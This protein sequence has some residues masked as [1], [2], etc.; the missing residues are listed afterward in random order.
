MIAS[1]GA[2]TVLLLFVPKLREQPALYGASFLY[3][4]GTAFF[5]V[6]LFQGLERLKVAALA[7]GV[8][9]LLTV[10]AL[11]LFVHSERD[12]AVAAAIQASVQVTATILVLPILLTQTQLHWYRPS[13]TDVV[14]AFKEGW[15]LFVSGFALY[16][17][18]SST[19][20]VLG[21]VAS[22]PEVGYYSAADKLVKAAVSML[23]PITQALYPHITALKAASLDSALRLIR[24][25]FVS[26]G[27]LA[28]CTSIATLSLAAPICHLF[29]G[30]SFNESIHV[31]QWLSPLPLLFGLMSV[32]GTQTMLVFKMD[33][34]MSRIMFA[35]AL[36]GIPLI[37]MLSM[38]FGAQGA[39][40]GSTVL[41]FAMV[42]AMVATLH[43][44]G[45]AVWQLA[46]S[47]ASSG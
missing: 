34:A 28:L 10:P 22:K 47:E 37:V 25:S 4:V 9:R 15:P 7:L 16:L 6:W 8:A 14:Q 42:A 33:S 36:A 26:T 24:K 44:R 32:F 21:F 46:L 29:L 23:S 11:F 39:A 1:G 43:F 2:L 35:S 45:L 40:A 18:T 30:S 38:P 12:C 17:S 20:V 5:P 27:I 13:F 31:L 19:A 3:V 41:A